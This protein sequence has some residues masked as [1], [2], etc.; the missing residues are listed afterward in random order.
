[1]KRPLNDALGKTSPLPWRTPARE[2]KTRDIL[3]GEKVIAF[4]VRK[5][6]ALLIV[7]AINVLPELVEALEETWDSY[8]QL[9]CDKCTHGDCENCTIGNPATAALVKA[10]EVG[11]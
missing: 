4:N 3:S 1:M 5:E 8:K 6:D 7:H 2:G 11:E 10:Q 9:A